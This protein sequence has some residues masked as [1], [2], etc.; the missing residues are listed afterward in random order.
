MKRIFLTTL[1]LVLLLGLTASAGAQEDPA[2]P[3]M[4]LIQGC[5]NLSE[6]DCAILQAAHAN[7]HNMT[8]FGM[9]YSVQFASENSDIMSMSDTP[10]EPESLSVAG[11]GRVLLN[12][13]D[14]QHAVQ[15][16]L[17]VA[18]TRGDEQT[19]NETI[20]LIVLGQMFY[21]EV[22][23]MPLDD[24][25]YS[26]WIGVH[27]DDIPE[28]VM[29]SFAEEMGEMM[30]FADAG[31]GEDDLFDLV[32]ALQ[33]LEEL[34][35]IGY[36]RLPDEE[37]MGQTMYPFR[38][39]VSMGVLF[40]SEAMMDLLM[41]GGPQDDFSAMMAGFMMLF[42]QVM[43]LDATVTQWV[44]ADDGFIHRL[45]VD[46]LF[47]I[48]PTRFDDAEEGMEP[49]FVSLQFEVTLSDINSAAEI[50]APADALILTGEQ[51]EAVIQSL[52]ERMERMEGE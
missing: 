17:D 8:S 39:N 16:L 44:G 37:L 50:V 21:L 13:E 40:R 10:S 11:S 15:T 29:E 25:L 47:S 28:E 18:A 7:I 9:Q 4:Q 6:D 26:G 2:D 52:M 22:K 32:Q 30:P 45:T 12:H 42:F 51:A 27:M 33:M 38:L 36:E 14:M 49:G 5:F 41:P 1:I 24:Q 43:D 3:L 19:I 48:D 35:G 31:P 46:V 20:H 23:D 34:G